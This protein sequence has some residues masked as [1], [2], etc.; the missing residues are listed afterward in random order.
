M[1]R[2]VRNMITVSSQ[3]TIMSDCVWVQKDASDKFYGRELERL[4][5]PFIWP[6]RHPLLKSRERCHSEIVDFKL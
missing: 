5:S 2:S 4:P 1:R 6:T 3:G